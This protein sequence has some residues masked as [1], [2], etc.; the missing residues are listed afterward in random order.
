MLT[1]TTPPPD[2]KFAHETNGLFLEGCI[3][4]PDVVHATTYRE[5]RFEMMPSEFPGQQEFSEHPIHSY[6]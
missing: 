3:T 4:M 5:P 6:N 2:A 1:G